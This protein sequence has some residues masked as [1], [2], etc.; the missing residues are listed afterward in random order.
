MEDLLS[1]KILIPP[2][3]EQRKVVSLLQLIDNRISTQNKIIEKYESL[4]QAIIYRKKEDGMHNG[5]WQKTVLSKV[6]KEIIKA[7]LKD[8][9]NDA[10][11]AWGYDT[12]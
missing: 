1:M 10:L 9:G 8:M 12:K 11:R 4:I 7:G 5:N 6:L 2:Q 3:D